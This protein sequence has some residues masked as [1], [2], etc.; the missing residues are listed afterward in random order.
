MPLINVFSIVMEKEFLLKDLIIEKAKLQ[1]KKAE[2][3]SKKRKD[4][5]I[6][7]DLK[8]F[9]TGLFSFVAVGIFLITL[10]LITNPD[11]LWA[12]FPIGFWGIAIVKQKLD[13]TYK[14]T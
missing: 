1:K 3:D 11:Y 9:Q 10:N 13:C 2:R 8:E 14:I 4:R 12:A 7:N 6:V 5:R